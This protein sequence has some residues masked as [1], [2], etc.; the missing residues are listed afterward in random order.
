VFQQEESYHLECSVELGGCDLWKAH[1]VRAIFI[2]CG[3]DELL[4][5]QLELFLTLDIVRMCFIREKAGSHHLWYSRL[6][7]V[8]VTLPSDAARF[9]FFSGKVVS[10]FSA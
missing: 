10:T 5:T 1:F 6:C 2:G 4:L 9:S 8:R 3:L 7:S